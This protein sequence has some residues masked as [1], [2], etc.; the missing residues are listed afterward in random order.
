MNK[1]VCNLC[2]TSYPE[3]ATQC[4]ICGYA[5]T[6]ESV[7]DEASSATPYTYV[8]GGRFSKANVKKRN[9]AANTTGENIATVD[10]DIAPKKKSG[11]GLTITVIILLLAIIAVLAY[12]ALR[13]FLPN[14]VLF[15][16]LENLKRPESVQ[17]EEVTPSTD[18]IE[19]T[20]VVTEPDLYCESITIANTQLQM[21]AVGAEVKLA[22]EVMPSNTTDLLTFTSSDPSV[23]T[24]DEDG[25]V[26]AVGEGSAI[27]YVT[28]GSA[29]A[30]CEVLCEIPVEEPAL[31]LNRKEITFNNEG[32]SWILYDGDIS[33]TDIIWSSDDNSVATI[34]D[35][36]VLAVGNG[37]TT[38]YGIYNNETVSCL[39]HCKFEAEDS[40][41]TGN[42]SEASG[43]AKRTY[44]LYNPTG[45]A[46]DV[47]L[48]VG[49]QFTLKLV[50]EEKNEASG[51]E[52]KIN[53]DN[54]CSY[55]DS[56]VKALKSGTTEITAT[57]EGVTYTCIVRVN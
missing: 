2:G 33:V 49:D 50:D 19:E 16:G 57:Y 56:I 45:Y 48:N 4:P 20:E 43:E 7:S 40:S 41:E 6:A 47:T 9:Q 24:V 21:F 23:A 35:G 17:Q 55:T 18:D 29:S 11:R 13:F 39:I 36:K 15:E 31:S 27:I 14:N 32:E 30:E 34:E 26:V 52:W 42:I 53:N 25:T 1:V 54:I 22:V 12:I 37:D 44:K 38:V 8:K 28:C 46:D 10:A 5:R 51:A 3:N